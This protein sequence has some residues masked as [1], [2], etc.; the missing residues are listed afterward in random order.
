MP[1][2]E[3]TEEATTSRTVP[4]TGKGS[5]EFYNGQGAGHHLLMDS[6]QIG[7]QQGEVSNTI[8]YLV[9]TNLG[10]MFL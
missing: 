9:S 1:G 7:W 5:E 2:K 8:S 4:P 6:F 3:G 10:S